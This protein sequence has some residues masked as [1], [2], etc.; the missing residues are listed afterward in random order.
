[1]SLRAGLYFLFSTLYLQT[2]L[3][4]SERLRKYNNPVLYQ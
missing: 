1:M 3:F 2:A 4:H